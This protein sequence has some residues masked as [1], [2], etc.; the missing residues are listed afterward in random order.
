MWTPLGNAK[1]FRSGSPL[2][3]QFSGP[4][5]K[6]KTPLHFQSS[7]RFGPRASR[8]RFPFPSRARWRGHAEQNK[9]QRFRPCPRSSEAK[10]LH[11][12][13][14]PRSNGSRRFV[15]ETP[16]APF[17]KLP[18]PIAVAE[19]MRDDLYFIGFAKISSAVRDSRPSLGNFR[20]H[21]TGSKPFFGADFEKTKPLST[22]LAPALPNAI[23]AFVGGSGTGDRATGFLR[24]SHFAKL[25]PERARTGCAIG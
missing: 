25:E 3:R 11:P 8:G 16:R 14:R 5:S 4:S 15:G 6:P 7:R 18:A 17:Q 19:R 21:N 24:N 22:N 10:A 1:V 13:I 23:P 20:Q 12:E 2:G 9:S